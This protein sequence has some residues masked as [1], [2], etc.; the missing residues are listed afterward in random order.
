MASK[1]IE[2]PAS[3][4][5]SIT[6]GIP[7]IG[8]VH[9]AV[10]YIDNS[11]NLASK[12]NLQFLATTNTLINQGDIRSTTGVYTDQIFDN[13]SGTLAIDVTQAVLIDQGGG[14]NLNWSNPGEIDIFGD[15]FVANSGIFADG[16]IL[17]SADGTAS[18]ASGAMTVG[19]AGGISVPGDTSQFNQ[20]NLNGN[21]FLA[22]DG[23]GNLSNDLI[24]WDTSGTFTA[25][26]LIS[27]GNIIG[28]GFIEMTGALI[29][30]GGNIESDGFGHLT[31]QAGIAVNN[32]SSFDGGQ[33]NTDGLGT[34]TLQNI[35]VFG[36]VVGTLAIS[37]GITVGGSAQLDNGRIGTNGVGLINFYNNQVVQG[38]GVATNIKALAL[39]NQGATISATTLFTPAATATRYLVNI[40]LVAT[41]AGTSGTVSATLAWNDGTGARTITTPNITFGSLAAPV[42]IS[43]YILTNTAAVTYA[44]TVTA[45]VGTPKYELYIDVLR[46][47]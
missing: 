7:V 42:T 10:L 22:G 3:K 25:A 16:N 35:Q 15:L 36:T 2:L 24:N 41:T 17:L 11:G 26:V 33:I 18:F 1:D 13:T 19:P 34:M 43:Q 39:T 5:G 8:G 44:T 20:I 31:I 9:N 30:D 21:G 23:S 47:A 28:S 14:N 6:P 45:A 38:N 32:A 40:Y 37:G 29:V 46:L 4:A 12:S 27:N